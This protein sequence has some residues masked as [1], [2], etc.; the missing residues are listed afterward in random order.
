MYDLA[1]LA[2][3]STI[4]H[5]YVLISIVNNSSTMY[6]SVAFFEEFVL[7]FSERCKFWTNWGDDV[8][9]WGSM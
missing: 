4:D 8:D 7:K 1:L 6:Q 2:G 3:Q 5:D 9:E